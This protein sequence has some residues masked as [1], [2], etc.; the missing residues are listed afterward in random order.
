[1]PRT[2]L[3]GVKPVIFSC[4][5][6]TMT[7]AERAFFK[8]ETPF[9]FI[10]FARNIEDPDQVRALIADFR[11]C[12]DRNDAP[13]LVD[14]EGGRVQRFKE[15]HWFK[16]PSFGTLGKLYDLDV[17]KG[18]RA[19]I[20]ATRLIAADLQDV[21]VTV[22]CSPCLDL[23][24]DVTS[25]VIG[26][27]SFHENP[28]VVV[29]LAKIVVD[30]Y[31]NAGITPVI[32]HMPGHGRGSV[33]SHLELP[34]VSASVTDLAADF[35]PFKELSSAPWGM[36]AHIVFDEIDPKF[37]GTQS[38]IVINDIIRGEIGFD[39]VLLTD[40][41]NMNAL[42][43]SLGMRTIRAQEAGIDI[44]LHCSGKLDEMQEVM[45]ACL[46]MTED[47]IRRIDTQKLEDINL[48]ITENIENL[49][50][51]LATLLALV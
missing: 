33:D 31:L 22:N 35:L 36:T 3:S 19:T 13:V 25:S 10:L 7:N 4:E 12:V 48:H 32:K 43:G 14:Q 44:I 39:G 11:Q 18:E 23:S 28:D 50:E 41:L 8:Q 37:P 24:L 21:G 1:M 16:A 38:K 40:D 17:I 29:H 46:P 45:K 6:L 27:R 26:D 47:T 9:G 42:S 49:K 34:T 51:E 15:P 30:E 5:G 20:L 2:D